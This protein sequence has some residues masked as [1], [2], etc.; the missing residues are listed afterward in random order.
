MFLNVGIMKFDSL[1]A[2]AG[3][4]LF[5]FSHVLFS[6]SRE[7]M[8]QL[9]LQ[10]YVMKETLG[11][12]VG[13]GELRDG[14]P[15]GK[16]EYFL[17]YDRNIKYSEG[18]FINGKK[19]GVWRNYA[20]SLPMGYSDNYDLVRSS[21]TYKDGLLY[22]FKMGQDNLLVLIE[23]GLGEPYIS[24]LK[25][26]DES[27]ENSYRRTH[28][29]TY[30]P[31]YGETVESLQSRLIPMIQSQLTISGKKSELK[32]WTITGKLKLHKKYNEGEVVYQLTQQWDNNILYSTEEYKHNILREKTLYMNGDP[33]DIISYRYFEDGELEY[34]KQYKNDSIP[35]GKWI[36]N[37]PGGNKKYQGFYVN[38]KRDGKWKFWDKKGNVEVIKYKEGKPQ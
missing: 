33:N 3:L 31:E 28:G 10:N 19:E 8:I 17:I 5:C 30:T 9:E 22:R 7:G 14:V 1:K 24:E 21:E 13:E 11:E 25:R 16:W 23:E 37:Y 26:L 15:T 4:I 36:E 38:G 12:V 35:V 6:Q 32:Q 27:F 2:L 18:H 29:K 20:L 34:M